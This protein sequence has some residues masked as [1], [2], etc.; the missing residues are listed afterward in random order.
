MWRCCDGSSGRQVQVHRPFTRGQKTAKL[1][2]LVVIQFTNPNRLPDI[3][4]VKPGLDRLETRHVLV[5]I[6]LVLPTF[7]QDDGIMAGLAARPNRAHRQMNI[8]LDC[9]FAA[10]RIDHYQEL[11]WILG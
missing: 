7:P 3:K 10:A 11:V 5:N 6:C 8:C 1:V 2:D 9:R 4:A